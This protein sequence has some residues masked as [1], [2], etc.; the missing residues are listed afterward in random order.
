MHIAIIGNG[1][2]SGY[3]QRALAQRGI[4]PVAL[5]LREGRTAG[6]GHDIAVRHT[7]TDLPETTELLV[8]CAG[9]AGLAAHGPAAL[10]RGI[11]VL[12]LSIGALADARLEQQLEQAATHGQAQLILA[13]GAIGALDALRAARA[14]T[15]SQVRYIGRKPPQGWIGSP[16]AARLDLAHL[17]QAEVHFHGSARAAALAYPK[18]ANVAAAV[19]LA[20]LGWDATEVTLIADPALTQN[21][22]EIEAKGDFGDLRFS[23]TGNS[24]PENPK[25]SA[26]AA[27]SMI[28]AILERQKPVRF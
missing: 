23:I 25:S 18:N 5:I 3:V 9:H 7:V 2:I 17:K 19:A 14:G 22:H 10:K 8:D 15:L 11:D 12:T 4:P 16:A 24:L 20:S 6:L 1:A 27:M 26:L 21:H 13:S 28:S